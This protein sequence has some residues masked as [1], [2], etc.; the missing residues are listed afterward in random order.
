MSEGPCFCIILLNVHFQDMVTCNMRQK[1]RKGPTQE[2]F[3]TA[4]IFGKQNLSTTSAVLCPRVLVSA[5]Y[6]W[7]CT[8]KTWSHATSDKSKEKVPHKKLFSTAVSFGKQNL[9]TTSALLCPR[10][11]VSASCC[12][13]CTS[14]T[15]S[16][17]TCD[18]SKEKV[19]HKKLFTTAVSFGKQNLSTTSAVLCPRVLVSASYCWMCTSKTWSHATSDKSKEK[20]PH[21]TLFSTAVSFGKQNLSTTSAVLCPRV[22]VSA[23]YC[24]MCTSKTWSHAT[25]DKSKEKVPHKNCLQ[26][27]SALVSRI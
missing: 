7:M 14:K 19:P 15:W 26:Q 10:V 11:L 18:K 24:W 2:L 21:K 16:H 13:M 17:A 23:S 4:V 6:C 8:S 20:V 27:Q 1:Q 25:C 3:T 9:S 22:L 5:S 12:W